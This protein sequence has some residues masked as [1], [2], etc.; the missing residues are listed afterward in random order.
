[1]TG[2]FKL[3]LE[4]ISGALKQ[5]KTILDG[6]ELDVTSIQ[7]IV[8]TKINA[9]KRVHPKSELKENEINPKETLEDLKIIDEAIRWVEPH[10][11]INLTMAV[12]DAL[13][14]VNNVIVMSLDEE[15]TENV[16]VS[17]A[18]V[19]AALNNVKSSAITMLKL[20]FQLNEL[21]KKLGDDNTA[22]KSFGE[23]FLIQCSDAVKIIQ[24]ANLT[25]QGNS[26][27]Q[28]IK[29]WIDDALGKD[30]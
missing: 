14:M 7:L 1:M 28:K 5:T 12:S 26:Y 22:I 23:N 9:L 19:N 27:S 2:D 20:A 30:K 4:F 11:A 18:T 3:N 13:R 6:M 17:M 29:L 15:N 24:R 10:L 8:G 25:Y 21:T 16:Q